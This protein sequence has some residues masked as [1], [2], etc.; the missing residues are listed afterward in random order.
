[1][2]KYKKVLLVRHGESIWNHS[3]KFT[4]WSDIP[5]TNNGRKEAIIISKK[6]KQLNI[7]PNIFFSSVLDRCTETTKIIN[8]NVYDIKLWD[9]YKKN[10][11]NLT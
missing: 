4:G 1:M 9:Y 10:I 11:R 3:S 7:I 6:L 2:N 5:L 8:N